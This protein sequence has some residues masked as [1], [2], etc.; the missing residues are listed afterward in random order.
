MKKHL[1]P[2]LLATNIFIITAI[3][4]NYTAVIGF[5]P[6][7]L[8]FLGFIALGFYARTAKTRLRIVLTF[9]SVFIIWNIIYH[10]LNQ[11]LQ[12]LAGVSFHQH[13]ELYF[14][15]PL[16]LLE[17][18]KQQSLFNGLNIIGLVLLPLNIV[19]IFRRGVPDHGH[20]QGVAPKK[21]ELPIAGLL[22]ATWLLAFPSLTNA[23]S[24]YT[25]NQN[26]ERESNDSAL[27]QILEGYMQASAQTKM[28][29]PNMT[30]TQEGYGYFNVFKLDGKL[31][32]YSV[33]CNLP[34][35]NTW[36]FVLI[37]PEN[38]KDIPEHRQKYKF[39]NI[40]FSFKQNGKQF[41]NFCY[42]EKTLPVYAIKRYRT[43]QY[44]QQTKDLWSASFKH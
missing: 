40:G 38:V 15:A 19:A 4:E 2:I 42:A 20:P 9:F 44:S 1:L 29:R 3:N 33:N 24:Q 41:N 10:W 8:S 26:T 11:T 27:A 39:D 31:A 43:G 16:E 14:Q 12:T 34:D 22:L 18:A 5:W 28:I 17:K 13:P 35:V 6:H 7:V 37:H 21:L 32:Y 23:V 25:N 30:R 36:F